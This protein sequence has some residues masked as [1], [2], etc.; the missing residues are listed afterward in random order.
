MLA[1]GSQTCLAAVWTRDP[2]AAGALASRWGSVAVGSFDELLDRCSAVSFAVPPGVQADLAARAAE[3][4]KAVLLEKPLADTLDSGRRLAEVVGA[5]GVQSMLLL[6]MRFLPAV[7]QFL[8]AAKSRRVR[9]AHHSSVSGAFLAGPFARSPWRHERGVLYD[10]GPH[11]IDLLTAI[12]GPVLEIRAR[13]D[14][15]WIQLDLEHHDG[16][17]SRS[18]LCAHSVGAA[19][20][21]I[22]VSGPDGLL[23]LDLAATGSPDLPQIVSDEFAEVVRRNTAHNCDVWHGLELQSLLHDAER[24]LRR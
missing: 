14:H 13:D 5:S 12:L 18:T 11:A 19:I 3:H 2:G 22:E 24:V 1:T 6:T 15:G 8:R 20:N 21:S 10:V 17:R 9:S 23:Q 7:R 4:G 16:G